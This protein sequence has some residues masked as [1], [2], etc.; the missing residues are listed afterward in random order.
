MRRER[1]LGRRAGKPTTGS[2]K[3]NSPYSTA[4]KISAGETVAAPA[5]PTSTPAA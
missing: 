3:P 1:D 5:F 2:W 4:A